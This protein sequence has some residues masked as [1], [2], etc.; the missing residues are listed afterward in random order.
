MV[1]LGVWSSYVLCLV[2]GLCVALP[3]DDDRRA[4]IAG[5]LA[6]AVLATYAVSRLP[7]ETIAAHPR[8]ETFFLAWSVFDIV[9][10]AVIA[11]SDG[12]ARS[13]VVAAFFLPIVFAA[14]AYPLAW[15][16]LV[17]GL[18]VVAFF[19]VALAPVDPATPPDVAYVALHAVCLALAGAMCAV[20]A[21]LH[22]RHRVDLHR[23]AHADPLTGC[24][25]RRGFAERLAAE[26]DA[27]RPFALLQ[28]DVDRFKS[29]ND[30]L[31]HAEGDR[32]LVETAALAAA[33]VRAG[34]VVG[35]LGGD[36]FAVLLLGA[37]PQDADEVRGRLA[38][39]L[40][41]GVTI[42]VG[43]ACCPDD[44]RDPEG[45]HA[46]A[47]ADLYARKRARGDRRLAAA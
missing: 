5:V 31:G 25:N 42:S 8:S 22:R 47:D 11:I 16:V 38:A 27:G 9:G 45:L 28:L 39:G 43:L 20:Q 7:A 14:L 18:T 37:G 26:L 2:A 30:T 19:V 13:P 10:I 29:V 4:V 17:S 3:A 15:V 1:A 40:P 41:G 24:L 23:L 33:S 6:A 46:V 35:R 21:R 34:D 44:G 12:G 32:V 36:E